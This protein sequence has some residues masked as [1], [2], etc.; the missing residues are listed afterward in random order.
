MKVRNDDKKDVKQ[1]NRML[2]EL[3]YDEALEG[4]KEDEVLYLDNK[5]QPSSLLFFLLSATK[6]RQC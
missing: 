2:R 1:A 3:D 5:R 6:K 4:L